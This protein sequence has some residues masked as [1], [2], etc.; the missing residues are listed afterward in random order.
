MHRCSRFEVSELEEPSGHVSVIIKESEV[1]VF[2]LWEFD[3]IGHSSVVLQV[4]VEQVNGFR[5]E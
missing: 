5:F 2:E 1:G 3:W 4:V